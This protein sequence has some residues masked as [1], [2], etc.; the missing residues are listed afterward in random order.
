MD[1]DI[2]QQCVK[3]LIVRG[4]A[5]TFDSDYTFQAHRQR[6]GRYSAP[7]V[8]DSGWAYDPDS[9]RAMTPGEHRLHSHS[10]DRLGNAL[11]GIGP[12]DGHGEHRHN[13]LDSRDYFF[14]GASGSSQGI[15]RL[16]ANLVGIDLIWASPE[17]E[18]LWS[19]AG[20]RRL[21]G[22]A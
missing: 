4:L 16:G 17:C 5:A 2:A 9:F 22:D 7:V 20:P 12:V 6:I 15:A 13:V 3:G 18:P 19:S 11:A 10:L 21:G 1:P 14:M 8:R